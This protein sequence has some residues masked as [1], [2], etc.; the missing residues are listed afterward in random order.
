[1]PYQL[2]DNVSEFTPSE[3]DFAGR[4][5][6]RGRTYQAVPADEQWRFD[7]VDETAAGRA[8]D[9]VAEND[10]AAVDEEDA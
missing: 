7:V 1:M 10:L 4:T 3:G 6:R 2:R 5:F 8:E 9:D